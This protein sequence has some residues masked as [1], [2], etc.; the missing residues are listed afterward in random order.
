MVIQY[1]KEVRTIAIDNTP[2]KDEQI[3]KEIKEHSKKC[4]CKL[5][6]ARTYREFREN[7]FQPNEVGFEG[8]KVFTAR[9][10]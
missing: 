8:C 7:G 5:F 6:S 4:G 1:F 10:D 9:P 3:K 2:G